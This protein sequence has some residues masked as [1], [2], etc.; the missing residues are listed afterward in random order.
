MR[1]IFFIILLFLF[2]HQISTQEQQWRTIIQKNNCDTPNEYLISFKTGNCSPS[3]C[4]CSG[5]QCLESN[6]SDELPT[7]PDSLGGIFY[8]SDKNCKI[9]KY[10][11]GYPY[12]C[13]NYGDISFYIKCNPSNMVLNA[14]DGE[15]CLGDSNSTSFSLECQ[16]FG[17]GSIKAICDPKMD[18]RK[19][20]FD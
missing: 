16:L 6:C 19:K 10:I 2:Y 18:Q 12:S 17:D 15:I 5:N 8:Y 7:L 4:F 13:A 3:K 11:N 14:F 9:I 20:L 1:N